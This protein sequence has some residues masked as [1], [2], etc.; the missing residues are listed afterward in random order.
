M[1]V[2][3]AFPHSVSFTS[4]SSDVNCAVL[5]YYS[6]HPFTK[7]QLLW[8]KCLGAPRD[9][10]G[11]DGVVIYFWDC[12]TGINKD[13][14]CGKACVGLLL[15]YYCMDWLGGTWKHSKKLH[16][17][18]VKSNKKLT[19]QRHKGK[20]YIL[21]QNLRISKAF[22]FSYSPNNYVFQAFY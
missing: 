18:V 6:K 4:A 22:F 10:T 9:M 3:C 20:K 13:S 2:S 5:W 1:A 11:G 21:K 7:L 14:M 12:I 15:Q 8:L 17:G 19:F 16:L